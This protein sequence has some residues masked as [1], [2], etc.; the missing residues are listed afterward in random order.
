MDFFFW[1]YLKS[2]VY[3]TTPY[4]NKLALMNS[5]REKTESI[6]IEMIQQ[7]IRQGYL[8]RLKK[9]VLRGGRQVEPYEAGAADDEAPDERSVLKLS[10][11]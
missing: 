10:P 7:S 6:P 1:G 4:P 5:I 2:Q 8:N 3:G 11:V 9:C